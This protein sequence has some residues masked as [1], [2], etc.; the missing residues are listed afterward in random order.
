MR[1]NKTIF[2]NFIYFWQ[3]LQIAFKSSLDTVRAF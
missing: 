1:V 3:R 2:L